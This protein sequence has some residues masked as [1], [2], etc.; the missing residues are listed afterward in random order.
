MISVAGQLLGKLTRLRCWEVVGRTIQIS[1]KPSKMTLGSSTMRICSGWAL[2]KEALTELLLDVDV[3][4]VEVVG[5][6]S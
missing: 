3:V 5:G 2:P 4:A 6:D 1:A